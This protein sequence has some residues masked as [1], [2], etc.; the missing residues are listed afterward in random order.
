ME[1]PLVAIAAASTIVG[2]VFVIVTIIWFIYEIRTRS[3][4]IREEIDFAKEKHK[5]ELENSDNS[6][7]NVKKIAP[8][9]SDSVA[10]ILS[11]DPI[12]ASKAL[13][14]AGYF[15]YKTSVF[16]ERSEHFKE[17][18]RILSEEFGKILMDRLEYLSY[19]NEYNYFKIFLDAGTTIHPLFERLAQLA[20]SKK[21][22]NI[23]LEIISNN[24]PGVQRLITIANKND[25]DYPDIDIQTYLVPGEVYPEYASVTGTETADYVRGKMSGP[26]FSND[27]VSG[28]IKIRRIAVLTGNWIRL[29]NTTPIYPIPMARGKGHLDVKKAAFDSADEVYVIAPLGKIIKKVSLNEFND[30]VNSKV[31]TSRSGEN[32]EEINTLEPLNDQEPTDHANKLRLVTTSR[33]R[34]SILTSHSGGVKTLLSPEGRDLNNNLNLPFSECTSIFIP[35]HLE[36]E[37]EYVELEREI[38]HPRMREADVLHKI[39]DYEYHNS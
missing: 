37:N 5:Y 35:F 33:D 20:R 32:Y 12:W 39:Y 9:I 29:R 34:R 10:K 21:Y 36:T 23:N 16:G 3:K 15:P 31:R 38:P 14:S 2:A 6:W 26:S 28:N 1:D 30:I 7:E 18:K 4:M 24:L 13:T 11:N 19:N 17:E 8:Y 22:K 27:A 25:N